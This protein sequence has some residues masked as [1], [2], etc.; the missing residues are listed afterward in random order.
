M[1]TRDSILQKLG[2]LGAADRQWIVDRLSP[3]TRAALLGANQIPPAA[4][5][6][7][8]D[9][10]IGA[11]SANVGA[12]TSTQHERLARAS[13]RSIVALMANEPAWVLHALLQASNWPWRDQVLELS[14]V[15]VRNDVARLDTGGVRY[16]KTLI[17]TLIQET[18][19]LIDDKA[20]EVIDAQSPFETLVAKLGTRFAGRRLRAR[21]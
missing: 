21:A 20:I 8:G 19:P 14:S 2:R 3:I 10:S 1:K 18:A 11:S 15:T 6:P 7:L 13:A 9:S 17:D 5:R 16:A 4:N 12:Q